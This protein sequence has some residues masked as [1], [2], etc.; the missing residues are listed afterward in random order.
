MTDWCAV[1]AKVIGASVS[2][3]ISPL[4]ERW[5]GCT[6]HL[7]NTV[8]KST[9]DQCARYTELA[10]V[11]D[12]L[13]SLKTIVSTFKQS[14]R[15]SKLP[16][17]YGLLQEVETRFATAYTVTLR[18]IKSASSV[19]ALIDEGDS[20]PSKSARNSL[21]SSVNDDG[22][23]SLPAIQAIVYAIGSIIFTQK[24]LE[25]SNYPTVPLVLPLLQ[26]IYEDLQGA[27]DG[28]FV[29]NGKQTGPKVPTFVSRTL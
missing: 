19:F 13:K 26:D 20:Q 7:F 24:C 6:V 18:F 11:A 14:G 28:E 2:P 29:D 27:G 17:G 5:M 12:D 22:I 9:L 10:G 4:D 8:I 3:N 23:V 21:F 15:N 25:G 1:I 16:P